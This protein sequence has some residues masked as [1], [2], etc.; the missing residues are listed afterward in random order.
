MSKPDAPYIKRP[1][2]GRTGPNRGPEGAFHRSTPDVDELEELNDD[3]DDED[4]DDREEDLDGDEARLS[5]ESARQVA[6]KHD[7]YRARPED[8]QRGYDHWSRGAGGRRR[9]RHPADLDV[10]ELAGAGTQ[11]LTRLLTLWADLLGPL[12][13]P[14]LRL[15]RGPGRRRQLERY[16]DEDLDRDD[17]DLDEDGEE[18]RGRGRRHTSDEISVA[19][20]ISSKRPVQIS[21][22]LDRGIA[23]ERLRVRPLRATGTRAPAIKG[24][25]IDVDALERVVVHVVIPDDQPAGTYEG[26]VL[27]A[28]GRARRGLLRV[29]VRDVPAA[30]AA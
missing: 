14:A 10:L 5:M 16:R 23:Y 3:L 6:D 28:D 8:M 24:T 20:D 29:Q 27:S 11:A 30:P 17:P 25:S 18:P 7:P 19:L 2:S 1:T 26:T 21:L 4:E 15:G 22:E 12:L 9:R 13:P